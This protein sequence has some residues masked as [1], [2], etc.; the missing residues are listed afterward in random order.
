MLNISREQLM[1]ALKGACLAEIRAPKP[2]NVS[3]FS[4]G[5]GMTAQQFEASASAIAA[6]LTIS[7]ASV[8]ERILRAVQETQKTVGC[9]TNLG[10]VL[11]AAPLLCAAQQQ[12][13]ARELRPRLR[14]VLGR[15]TRQDAELAY[16][17]IR[18]AKPA[19]LGSSPRF[20]VSEKPQV[21]LLA[22]MQ[23]ASDR[24][25]I[26]RQYANGFADVFEVG[27]AHARKEYARFASEEWAVLSAYL[28]LLARFPDSHVV[29]K[30]GIKLALEVSSKA[31]GLERVWRRSDSPQALMPQLLALDA[32]LKRD[33]INPGTTAD[34]SV[35]SLL[36]LR[37]QDL[38]LGSFTGSW[39]IPPV[40]VVKRN[41]SKSAPRKAAAAEVSELCFTVKLA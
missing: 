26:A 24:D 12:H 36:A 17:A 29:R 23:E 7:G 35:A 39:A 25:S 37:L 22:A 40:T 5:H 1:Q 15:L 2:G 20:D 34:L 30:F 33:G 18:L 27:V 38:L 9:N 14:R 11:L 28:A 41:V 13:S 6:P 32:E 19:G 16:E 31:E 4:A 21:T 3:V 10:I 8:G